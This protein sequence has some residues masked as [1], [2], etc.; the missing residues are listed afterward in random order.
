MAIVRAPHLGRTFIMPAEIEA[1]LESMGVEY[2]RWARILTLP[3]ESSA[4]II[5]KTYAP[6]LEQYRSQKDFAG[7]DVLEL[8]PC[9]RSAEEMRENFKKEHWHGDFESYFILEG[10]GICYIHPAGEPAVSVEL[11]PGDLISIGK[12]IRHW[13]DVCPEARFRAVR[14]ISY[15]EKQ[16]TVYTRSGI[17]A[18]YESVYVSPAAFAVAAASR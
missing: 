11:E 1:F 6:H 8:N 13:C 7:Y 3:L 9:A 15:P 16:S 10:R 5:V 14:F 12:Y 2:Q 17:E 4:E 18:D